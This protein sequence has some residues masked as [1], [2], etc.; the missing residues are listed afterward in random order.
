MASMFDATSLAGMQLRNRFVRSATW[1]RMASSLGLVTPRLEN[2]LLALAE[3]GVSLIFPGY[4]FILSKE[5]PNPNMLGVHDDACISG[6]SRLAEKIHERGA[7]LGVQIAAGGSYTTWR[8]DERDIRGPSAVTHP[9]TGVTPRAMNME[10]IQEVVQ[11]FAKAAVRVRDAGCDC[12]QLHCAHGYLLSQFLTPFF[13]RR[14]DTYG[15]SLENRARLL[16]EVTEAM[17]GALGPDFPLL[18]KIN[19]SDRMQEQGLTVD[20]CVEVCKMLV[21]RGVNAIEVSGGHRS[22]DPDVLPSRPKILDPERQDYFLE[23][24]VRIAEAVDVPVISVGGHR[25]LARMES[26]LETTPVRY[27]S[28]CRTLL[29]EPDLAEKWRAN[30]RY[31]PRCVSCNLCFHEDGNICVF[32]RKGEKEAGSRPS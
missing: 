26:I 8:T 10:D 32:D 14:E 6:L 23:E 24:A 9:I 31:T 29:S 13:N 21:E 1:E 4:S 22:K 3:G 27:I 15:G 2:V 30:P 5:Q 25:D 16:C 28:L 12:V 19:G 20:E 18:I 7:C 17:R 11:G